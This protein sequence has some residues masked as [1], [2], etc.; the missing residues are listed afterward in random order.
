MRKLNRWKAP[1]LALVLALATVAC[2]KTVGEAVDDTTITTRV[3][4]W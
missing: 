2:G 4:V 3:N 1:V